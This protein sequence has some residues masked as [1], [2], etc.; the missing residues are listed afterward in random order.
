MPSP[1][2]TFRSGFFLVLASLLMA[3]AVAHSAGP[4][5][6]GT[7]PVAIGKPPV[8]MANISSLGVDVGGNQYYADAVAGHVIEVT[9]SGSSTTIA[10]GLSQPL[11]AVDFLGD[12]FVADTGTSRVLKIAAWP[13]RTTSVLASVSKQH[14]LALDNG[15]NLFL[16]S[17]DQLVE[18]P[19]NGSPVVISTIPGASLLGLGPGANGNGH[20]YIVSVQNGV[21]ATQLYTYS[22]SGGS[23]TFSG[24]LKD[25][26]PDLGSAVLEAISVD[27]QGD[28]IVAANVAGHGKVVI[29]S[30]SGYKHALFTA[31]IATVPIAQ[32]ALGNLY[33]VNGPDLIQIQ[34][35]A[36]NVGVQDLPN[37]FGYYPP[38]TTLNFGAPPNV[39]WILSQ[40]PTGGQ[41]QEGDL[42]SGSGPLVDQSQLYF[43]YFPSARN[44]GYT[45]GIVNITDQNNV[46][47]LSI[48]LVAT[49]TDG[50]YAAY[51]LPA[52]DL[53][54]HPIF[55]PVVTAQAAAQTVTSRCP[56]GTF[57]LNRK[58]GSVTHNGNEIVSG[59]ENVRGADVDAQGN[60]YVTQRGVAG[61]LRVAADGLTSRI[62]TDIA[63]PIGS[64]MDGMGNLYV[65]NGDDIVRVTPD[66]SEV[67]FATPVTNG[68]Y[69]SLL[70]I[71]VDLFNNVYAGYGTSPN[72]TH[73]AILKFSPAG[74]HSLV[75]TD[76]KQPTGLAVYPCGALFF[77]DA[78]RGTV[79]VVPGYKLE[80]VIGFGLTDPT[81][82]QCAEGGTISGEDPGIAGGQF[83][84]SP[85]PFSLGNFFFNYN[86]GNVVVGGSRSITLS[87]VAV[88]S[89]ASA[90]GP[91][92]Q[93]IFFGGP[94]PNFLPNQVI[95]TENLT[96]IIFGFMPTAVGPYG[97]FQVSILDQ[98]DT[99]S[100]SGLETISLSGT[101]VN[102]P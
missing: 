47:T 14:A 42:A 65:L 3:P 27:P 66:D 9:P 92:G 80:K 71:A 48:P 52:P 81:N 74:A 13:S 64:A 93:A 100:F 37:G 15:N 32:D 25:F 86:F 87:S 41:F 31:G 11:I 69:T 102:P 94:S 72:A 1:T 60:L 35:G 6:L 77:A 79:A 101:G 56:C 57:A 40:E 44:V 82:L 26:L 61:V 63:D 76:T 53:K 78:E 96:E 2:S 98:N 91:A 85:I 97:P 50:G 67:V 89:S 95:V 90:K 4:V 28:P 59:L 49:A 54:A 45:T 24:P 22:Y 7:N 83:S 84:V 62:A 18:I 75:P 10:T 23:G 88:G 55:Q 73:G 5:F 99:D 38:E 19:V 58:T 20:L 39:T 12:V 46:T 34:L 51:Y 29:S 30:T 21:Y 16:L 43:Y 70:S 8:P 68:G 33:Y 36:V 17:G